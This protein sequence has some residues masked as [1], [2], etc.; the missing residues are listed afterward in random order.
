MATRPFASIRPKVMPDLVSMPCARAMFWFAPVA[1]RELPYSVPKNQYNRPINTAR[2]RITSGM[3]L[4]SARS[5][6]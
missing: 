1:R 6:T 5:R 4:F 2:N 3:G